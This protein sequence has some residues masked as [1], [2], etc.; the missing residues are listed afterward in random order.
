MRQFVEQ[1]NVILWISDPTTQETFY[2]N[3]RLGN[4]MEV[5]DRVE[6]SANAWLAAIHPED[7]DKVRESWLQSGGGEPLQL[8]YRLVTTTGEVRWVRDR[9]FWL[10]SRSGGRN[11]WV[12]VAEE[13]TEEKQTQLTLEQR[14]RELEQQVARLE[15]ELQQ[16][17]TQLQ[18][19]R[20]PAR[21]RLPQTP[22]PRQPQTQIEDLVQRLLVL[23]DTVNEG[24]T[25]SDYEGNFAIYNGKMTEIT[26]YSGEEANNA[27]N[28]LALLYPDL[29]DR[30]RAVAGIERVCYGGKC[31][32][33]ETTIRAKDGTTKTLL[34][35]S[36]SIDYQGKPW[37]LSAYRDISD[38]KRAEQALKLLAEREG[39]LRA[40]AHHIRGTLQLPD[41]LNVAAEAARNF[42]QADRALIYRFH[43][44][45]SG[46]V[47]VESSA[48]TLPSARSWRWDCPVQDNF[49][50][51]E[52]ID[53][54]R[55]EPGL[56]ACL[57]R[58]QIRSQFV[59]PIQLNGAQREP[60]LWGLLVVHQCSHSR[61]WQPLEVSLLS[62]LATQL[63]VAIDQAERYHQLETTNQVLESQVAIDSLTQIA[64]R[65]KF[66]EY[67]L[68]EWKRL[69][70]DRQPLSLIVCDVDFFKA[71]NDSCGHQRGDRCLQQIARCLRTSVKRAADLVTRYGGEEFAIVLPNTPRA[72][73]LY[74]SQAIGEQLRLLNLPHP[75]S[76][77]SDRVTLSLGVATTIPDPAQSPD[78]IIAAADRALYRA[79]AEGR[80]RAVADEEL[81]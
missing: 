42:L 17:R 78:L 61:Q 5:G 30:Q 73:A 2:R 6:I 36:S 54:A 64:N 50:I 27:E 53:A 80:D 18:K 25:V 69:A 7:R 58:L 62:Q 35:S 63:G 33:I 49:Q 43:R 16:M 51:L 57:E 14:N 31:R 48:S 22:R 23:I 26:G 44:D 47:A 21:D 79:K 34:V 13:V 60:S 38:R 8:E 55:I 77:I 15:I 3:S 12:L 40:I 24:I 19:A 11:R 20:R 39:F 68:Q 41:I 81:V 75:Q 59:I 46:E 9:S 4:R 45:G 1:L 67:I 66:D 29:E 37:F 76:P 52:D 10:V 71:Y 72:G 56:R 70:R 32:D 28:F 74:L 65:R